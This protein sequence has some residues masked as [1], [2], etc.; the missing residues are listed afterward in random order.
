MFKHSKSVIIL[1]HYISLSDMYYTYSYFSGYKSFISFLNNQKD[2]KFVI[3]NS[4]LN[5]KDE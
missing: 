1:P 4:L 5:S 2:E 3:E